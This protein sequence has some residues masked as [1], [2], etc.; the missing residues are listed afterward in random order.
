MKKV[1]AMTRSNS[2][3]EETKEIDFLADIIWFQLLLK[4]IF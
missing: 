4:L 3:K 1:S 2:L